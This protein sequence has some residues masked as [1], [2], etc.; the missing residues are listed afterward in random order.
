[1]TLLFLLVPL[2][3]T[4]L[5]YFQCTGDNIVEYHRH[6]NEDS[7]LVAFSIVVDNTIVTKLWLLLLLI[8]RNEDDCCMCSTISCKQVPNASI[9]MVGVGFLRDYF[10]W[11]SSIEVALVRYLPSRVDYLFICTLRL[12]WQSATKIWWICKIVVAPHK[13]R[14][15]NHNRSSECII[16]PSSLSPWHLVTLFDSITT[17]HQ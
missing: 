16:L 5:I 8:G 15:S 17:L 9:M 1:M 13:R 2:I 4:I 10:P 12:V 3:P 11:R 7:R 14:W 6:R